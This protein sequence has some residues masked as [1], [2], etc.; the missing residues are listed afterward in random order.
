MEAVIA[1]SPTDLSHNH[2]DGQAIIAR[3]SAVGCQPV[4][5]Y[6]S[7]PFF[8][9]LEDGG[10]SRLLSFVVFAVWPA[11]VDLLATSTQKV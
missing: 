10:S 9:R 7:V 1:M 2:V 8:L 6:V 3:A 4:A 11:C 5:A